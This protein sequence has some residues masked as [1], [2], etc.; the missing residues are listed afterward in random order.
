MNNIPYLFW[1]LIV[2]NAMTGGHFKNICKEKLKFYY[3]KDNNIL[4]SCL[5]IK[6]CRYKIYCID[7]E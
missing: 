3:L 7:L 2:V 5:D 4:R 1:G 6:I